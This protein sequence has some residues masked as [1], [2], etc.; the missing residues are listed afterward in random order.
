MFFA[1]LF[2]NSFSK[3]CGKDVFGDCEDRQ[4]YTN[5]SNDIT[6]RSPS[7]TL[8]LFCQRYYYSFTVEEGMNGYEIKKMRWLT[9]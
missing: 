9:Q 8:C 3:R 5:A 4:E 7:H 6:G 2:L 1:T